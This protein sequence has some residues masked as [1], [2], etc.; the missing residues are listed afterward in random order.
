VIKT[1]SVSSQPENEIV[2]V[3]RA[4]VWAILTAGFHFSLKGFSKF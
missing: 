1:E 3:E 2:F 4:K